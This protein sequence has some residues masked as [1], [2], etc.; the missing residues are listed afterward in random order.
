MKNRNKQKNYL[1]RQCPDS[2]RF[3]WICI[4]TYRYLNASTQII[5]IVAR[6]SGGK[7]VRQQPY[8]F[9]CY[10]GGTPQTSAYRRHHIVMVINSSTGIQDIKKFSYQMA[11]T[12]TAKT[13]HQ[14][15]R[16]SQAFDQQVTSLIQKQTIGYGF[17][18]KNLL[19][20]ITYVYIVP[21][22]IMYIHIIN[23][24]H[25]IHYTYI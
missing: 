21:I 12:G 2:S 4:A 9:Q 23:S 19:V 25:Q 6:R 11:K 17:F 7:A 20:Y 10:I 3:V 16:L 8:R 22:C 13:R 14:F 5:T 15:A 1:L 18:N 24:K